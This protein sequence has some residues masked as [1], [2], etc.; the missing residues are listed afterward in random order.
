M[1]QYDVLLSVAIAIVF[2][3]LKIADYKFIIKEE[4]DVKKNNERFI[5][6]IYR[7]ICRTIYIETGKNN[8]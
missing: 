2:S 8:K 6:S 4:M 7:S 5:V 1:E 3:L